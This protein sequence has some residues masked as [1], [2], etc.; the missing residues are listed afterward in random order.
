MPFILKILKA[1]KPTSFLQSASPMLDQELHP[2]R[3][4]I[5]KSQ[6]TSDQLLVQ[7]TRYMFTKNK[8]EHDAPVVQPRFA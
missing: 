2:V 4:D 3:K 8:R 7:A 5:L 6:S 1:V